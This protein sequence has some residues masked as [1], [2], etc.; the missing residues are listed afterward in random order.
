MRRSLALTFA[1][2]ALLTGLAIADPGISV[3][4]RSGVPIIRLSGSYPGSSYSVYRSDASEQPFHLLGASGVLCLGDCITSDYDARAGRTYFYRF[5]LTLPDGG[6]VSYGPYSVTIPRDQAQP[7]GI[8]VYPNPGRGSATIR[9]S[10]SGAPDQAPVE[11]EAT[12]YDLQ[13]RALR[14]LQR[15]A[16]ARGTTAIHW[17]GRAG[18]GHELGSGVY[19]LRVRSGAGI[20]TTRLIRTR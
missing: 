10:L 6:F 4:Y 14:T 3:S 18:D 5:D 20:A 17:D 1:A 11:T 19:Y 2:I 15:G 8:A 13:G 16:L 7:I 12:L 9:I